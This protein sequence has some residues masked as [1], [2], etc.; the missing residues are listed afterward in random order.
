MRR[1]AGLFIA[2]I[3][4]LSATMAHAASDGLVEG[5]IQKLWRGVVNTLT[6]WVE[7]PVQ[8][9][10]GYN[11]GFMG[12]EDNKI[13]GVVGG[14]FDGIGHS[15]GRTLSGIG[16]IAG[17]WAADAESNEGVGIRLDGE[18]AWDA[19]EPQ[20]LFEP[21]F[22]ESTVMPIGKKLVRGLTN[23]LLGFVELPGQI[24]KG[25]KE[26]A[27]DFGIV[28][29]LWYW[30]SREM[31]GLSDIATIIVPNPEETKGLAFEEEY[32]WDALNEGLKQ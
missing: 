22:N 2:L 18:Y 21:T 10:K 32:P 15:A 13:L 29:G 8:I 12:E 1:L 25:V 23:G 9:V 28:K 7:F 17:F 16:D 24:M 30:A 4:L 6:G 3:L 27:K 14:I 5:M 11:D 19:G 31:A 20:D 26:G